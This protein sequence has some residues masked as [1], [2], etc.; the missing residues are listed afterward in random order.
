MTGPTAFP[1]QL[2]ALFANKIWDR[3]PRT[4]KEWPE[5]GDDGDGG[6]ITIRRSWGITGCLLFS[7]GWMALDWGSW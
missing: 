7:I 3:D 5:D 6:D 2:S 1:R 4:H